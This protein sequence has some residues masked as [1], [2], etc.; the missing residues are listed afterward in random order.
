MCL[1]HQDA[2]IQSSTPAINS[3]RRSQRVSA[4]AQRQKL[5]HFWHMHPGLEEAMGTL[6]AA[7][8]S[9]LCR[10]IR[11]NHFRK[12]TRPSYHTGE[13]R[14]TWPG[15]TTPAWPCWSPVGAAPHTHP[16]EIN[17]RAGA[18]SGR[19]WTGPA[20]RAV[21]FYPRR[22]A[23]PSPLTEQPRDATGTGRKSGPHRHRVHRQTPP[24]ETG[25][26]QRQARGA[27]LEGRWRAGLTGSV[28]GLS[29][30]TAIMT[31][32][33][34]VGEPLTWLPNETVTLM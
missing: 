8:V 34:A 33:T 30:I 15:P 32:T 27:A 19:P 9:D 2:S 21:T 12:R 24:Y 7:P 5:A 22:P 25:V 26:N 29:S 23:P 1:S 18:D 3:S 13:G 28:S 20:V 6:A 11:T 31:K 16:K 17:R 10:P 14:E 4:T